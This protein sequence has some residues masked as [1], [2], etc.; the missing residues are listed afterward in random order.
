MI[1]QD[2]KVT[3]VNLAKLIMRAYKK[4][5]ETLRT[6]KIFCEILQNLFP[7]YHVLSIVK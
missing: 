7:A 4:Q 6:N 3:K 1:L 5:K 2:R